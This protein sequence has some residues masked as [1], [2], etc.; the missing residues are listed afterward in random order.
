[1]WPYLWQREARLRS[2]VQALAARGCPVLLNTPWSAGESYS[3]AAILVAEQGVVGRYDKRH[4]VP[5]GEYVPAW[6]P[7]PGAVARL[8]G[9]FVAGS[10]ARAIPWNGE[11]LGMAICYEIVFPGEVA[12]LVRG[13]A[14][15][16]VTITNDAW[17]GDTAAPWQHLR[18]ARFRAA[19]NR[20]PVLRAAITGVSAAI[21]PDGAVEGQLGVGEEG[22]IATSVRGR[23]DRTLYSRA[24]WASPAVCLLAA[25]ACCRRSP[26]Q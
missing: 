15:V 1:A 8:V 10:E 6:L 24:P 25:L 9:S 5:F 12:S 26:T 13:G 16:L 20:R 22:V 17:Y 18:A 2:D 11:S 19:E 23:S 4:L 21:G 3:N 14:T 7:V